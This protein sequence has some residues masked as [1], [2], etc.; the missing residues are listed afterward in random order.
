MISDKVLL[1]SDF[2]ST[3]LK[4]GG[5]VFGT[6]FFRALVGKIFVE[7]QYYFAGKV[8]DTINGNPYLVNPT[9]FAIKHTV[10]SIKLRKSLWIAISQ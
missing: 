3:F 1:I 5:A 8:T 10:Y 7:P 2:T 4:T 6:I 9:G